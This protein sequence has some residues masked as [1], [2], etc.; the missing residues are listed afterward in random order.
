[1]RFDAG[2]GRLY[3]ALQQIEHRWEDVDPHW[4][5]AVRGEFEEKIWEPLV[6]FSEDAL[7]AIDRL[8]QLF[9]QARNE[10]EGGFDIRGLS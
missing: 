9:T 10:C 1:M 8:N 2:R 6:T 4:N 7:R 5:D 3:D